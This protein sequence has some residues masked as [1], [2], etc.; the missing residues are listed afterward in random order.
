M[1]SKRT[2]R[3]FLV[4]EGTDRYGDRYTLQESSLATERCVWLGRSGCL[5][6]SCKTP[7][8]LCSGVGILNIRQGLVNFQLRTRNGWGCTQLGACI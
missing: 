5:P 8:P 3:G 7:S 6:G 2:D 4:Y 1:K